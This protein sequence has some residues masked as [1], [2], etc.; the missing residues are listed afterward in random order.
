MCNTLA[1]QGCLLEDVSAAVKPETMQQRR[2]NAINDVGPDILRSDYGMFMRQTDVSSSIGWFNQGPDDQIYGRFARGFAQPQS[3]TATIG[4]ELD[5]GLWGGLP[6]SSSR[7]LTI[8]V[9]WLSRA[10]GTFTIGYDS[11]DGNSRTLAITYPNSDRW[12]EVCWR[13]T[14]GRFGQSP[15]GNDVW[16]QNSDGVGEIFDSV[17]VVATPNWESIAVHQEGCD[18]YDEHGALMTMPPPPSPPPCADFGNNCARDA[19]RGDCDTRR[20]VRIDCPLSC[21]ICSGA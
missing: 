9:A 1:A 12:R 14:D 3:P 21:G 13:V 2:S 17:E 16:L 4:L 11:L 5:K 15:S 8:R 10:A 6:M 18:V 19:G 7:Q 20:S